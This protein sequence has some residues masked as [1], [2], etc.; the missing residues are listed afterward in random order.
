MK[1]TFTININGIIFHIDEDAYE[2]LSK[3]LNEINRKFA[4]S[5]EG[6]E[7]ISDIEARIAELFQE[8]VNDIKQV[9]NISDINNVIE[10]MGKPED[11]GDDEETEE[12]ETKKQKYKTGKTMYRDTENAKIGGV[13]SGLSAYFGIDPVFVRIL[14]LAS[15][16]ISGPII[17]II[18]WIIIPEA[19]TTAQKLE[20]KGEKINV[21]NI[22]KSIKDEFKNVKKNVK[23]IKESGQ[24]EE[25]RNVFDRLLAIVFGTISFIF[26]IIMIIVGVAFV[27]TGLFVLIG[28]TGSFFIESW[29]VNNLTIPE[30]LNIFFDNMNVNI[31]LISIVLVIGIPV[32]AII[33]AGVKMIFKI[34]VKNKIIGFTAF[35]TWI[36]G[37]IMLAYVTMHEVKNHTSSAN[38]S[39]TIQIDTLSSDTLYLKLGKDFNKNEDS[40][41]QICIDDIIAVSNNNN[42]TCLHGIPNLKI[43][44]SDKDNIEIKITKY[45]RGIEKDI[46]LNHAKEIE[47]KFNFKDSVIYF[48]KYFDIPMDRKWYDQ[49]VKIILYI[50]E[51][52]EI[53]IDKKL[54][55]L[56]NKYYRYS[57]ID[58]VVKKKHIMNYKV[59]YAHKQLLPIPKINILG[60]IKPITKTKTL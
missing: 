28:I 43:K 11:M 41:N 34:K 57:R 36:I 15:F 55:Y 30:A 51:G 38:I 25:S 4:S 7:I 46:A 56:L 24:W 22:E 23:K 20:M 8:K 6:R 50:P 5:D 44:T 35:F 17:Y 33:Y 29:G 47:Y 12:K 9:I 39:E 10:I 13:G 14:L 58:N 49:N 1:K 59:L 54:Q 19:K 48:D 3:Y 60:K 40:Y 2:I 37:I 31:G 18:L 45:A 16:F 53:I 27:I 26:R 42:E 21:E 52:Q 32:L